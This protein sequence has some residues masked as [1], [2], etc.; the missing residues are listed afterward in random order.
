MRDKLYTE[1]D[2]AGLLALSPKTLRRWRWAGK[3]PGFVK[4]GGAV[5]YRAGDLEAFVLA[6]QADRKPQVA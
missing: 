1:L 3:G 6:G 4:I 5:R 2:A